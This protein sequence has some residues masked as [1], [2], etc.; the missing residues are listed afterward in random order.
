MPLSRSTIAANLALLAL[1][2]VL[3]VALAE[4]GLRFY[5]PLGQRLMGDQ[6]RL[7]R[8]V[9]VSFEVEHDGRAGSRVEFTRNSVGFRGPDPPRD[10]DRR[11]TV[12]AVGGSTTECILLSEGKSWPEVMARALPRRFRDPWVNNAGLDGHST[13]GH[14][15]LLESFLVALRPRVVAFLVGINDV[16]RERRTGRDLR[17]QAPLHVRLARHSALL[18]TLL[19][20]RRHLA[21]EQA[22]LRHERI[23]V[24]RVGQIPQQL[25]LRERLIPYH[26][27]RF[28]P[29]FRERLE[30]LVRTCL[31]HGIVPVLITQPALFGYAIDPA[32]GVD[33]SRV[34][35]KDVARMH[36]EELN[37]GLAWRVLEEYNGVT[38]EVAAANGIPLV[39]LALLPK[40]SRLYYDYL[41]FTEQG[42]EAVGELVAAEVSP[43]LAERFPDFVRPA[44]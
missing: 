31:E 9:R 21:A 26:R 42:A 44:G 40:D 22:G 2:A 24:S 29:R 25:R 6:I 39:D 41:H 16:G 7:Q 17:Y 36:D 38:R 30:R 5:D 11:L 18:A 1:G 34:V 13:H 3:S 35:V 43:A 37:G 32:T 14:Q 12:V 23:D 8:N 20:V 4:M 27:Q 33:L 10:F 19:N 28:L 15:V